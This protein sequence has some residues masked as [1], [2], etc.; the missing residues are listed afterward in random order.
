L[1]F[2]GYKTKVSKNIHLIILCSDD[3][4]MV[5]FAS[6][7]QNIEP[8]RKYYKTQHQNWVNLEAKISKWKLWKR[9]QEIAEK[10]VKLVQRYLDRIA[11][12]K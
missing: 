4:L 3:V 11:R 2:Q 10:S 6:Y 9:I 5:K 8:L 1:L 12:G 7:N